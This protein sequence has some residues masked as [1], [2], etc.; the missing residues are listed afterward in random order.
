MYRYYHAIAWHLFRA[1]TRG[2]ARV[3]LR[4]TLVN[5]ALH[6]YWCRIL[7]PRS[8]QPVAL[9]LISVYVFSREFWGSHGHAWLVQVPH[10]SAEVQNIGLSPFLSAQGLECELPLLLCLVCHTSML[11]EVINYLT[12]IMN[13]ILSTHVLYIVSAPGVKPWDFIPSVTL[14]VSL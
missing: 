9:L 10:A 11:R 14:L 6:M 13:S 1:P 8:W 12:S 3:L 2:Q 7:S 4:A 5:D